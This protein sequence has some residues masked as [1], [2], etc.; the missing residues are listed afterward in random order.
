MSLNEKMAGVQEDSRGKF[1]EDILREVAS[2]TFEELMLVYQ[3]RGETLSEQKLKSVC[4]EATG[5]ALTTLLTK[6]YIEK[7]GDAY[8]LT[9]KGAFL[10]SYL[11]NFYYMMLR[12]GGKP[13][14][15]DGEAAIHELARVYGVLAEN[16]G[17]VE[18]SLENLDRIVSAANREI[19]KLN[20]LFPKTGLTRKPRT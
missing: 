19:A 2:L 12:S 18:A 8:L 4:G 13:S 9:P 1:A 5:D 17:A 16:R 11:Y 14:F 20:R 3:L 6:G 15:E 10:S 7:N